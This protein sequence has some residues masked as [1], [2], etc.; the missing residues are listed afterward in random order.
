MSIQLSDAQLPGGRLRTHHLRN[1]DTACFLAKRMAGEGRQ[2]LEELVWDQMCVPEICSAQVQAVPAADPGV[3]TTRSRRGP[4]EPPQARRVSKKPV[5]AVLGMERLPSQH[6][7]P[8]LTDRKLLNV[9]PS[10]RG[11]ELQEKEPSLPSALE[12]LPQNLVH[13]EGQPQSKGPPDMR[14]VNQSQ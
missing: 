1:S 6:K 14:T 13:K 12:D 3:R 9:R 4:A 10:C 11:Q 8:I 5:L 2:T 7:H